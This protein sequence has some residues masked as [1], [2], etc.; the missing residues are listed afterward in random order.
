VSYDTGLIPDIQPF[1][2]DAILMVDT[3]IGTAAP[4]PILELVARY[5]CAHLLTISSGGQIGTEQVKSILVS[6]QTKLADGLGITSF[7]VS[8]MGFDTSGK[9]A[10]WNK[11]VVNGV[12]ST[13]F[14]WAGS[15]PQDV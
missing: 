6:Y 8:A 7:G 12:A 2:N 1:I 4:D 13:T 3:I 5:L 14:F 10:A 11:K 15:P 9:L